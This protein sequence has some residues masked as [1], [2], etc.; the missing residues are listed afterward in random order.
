[1]NV[2]LSN[3]SFFKRLHNYSYLK[4]DFAGLEGNDGQTQKE[5]HS[6]Y[7]LRVGVICGLPD[8]LNKYFI[9]ELLS[10][11]SISYYTLDST[12]FCLRF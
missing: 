2:I 5:P 1:M 4:E 9:T 7:P 6:F 3:E 8:A 12:D 11:N 10:F